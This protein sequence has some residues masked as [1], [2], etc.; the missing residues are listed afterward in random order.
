MKSYVA[1]VGRPNVGKST[2]FN[3]IT[4]SRKAIVDDYPGVTRDRIYGD[5][6]WD[7]RHFALIDTGGFSAYDSEPFTGIIRGQILTAIQESDVVLLLFDGREGL[8]PVDITICEHLRLAGKPVLYLVN[9][10]DDPKHESA[11]SEFYRLGIDRLYPIS[12]S[13]GL[14]IGDVMDAVTKHLSHG[15][16]PQEPGDVLRLSVLGRPNVGKSSLINRI[17]DSDRLVVSSIPGTTRDAVDTMCRVGGQSYQLIDTAG[18]RRK[19]SV[20][21]KLEKFSV[22]KA[23]KAIDRSHIVLLLIDAA[24]GIVDQDITI[25]SY[26]AKRHRGCIIVLNKWDLAP[27]ALNLI[28]NYVDMVRERIKFLSFAPVLTTSALTGKGVMKIFNIVNEVSQQYNARIPT[29]RLNTMFQEIF[30]SHEPP[31]HRGRLVRCYYAAQI[32]VRPPTFVCFVNT[33]EGI[34]VSYERYVLNRIRP[35][36][37]LTKTPVR[38]IFRKRKR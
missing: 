11:V 18:I 3:R 36:S 31:R 25:A 14:G 12:A 7:E 8:N 21:Q 4:R 29:P 23:L 26:I 34:P 17:L 1:I 5:V 13:H 22:I 6:E 10:I 33:P 35:A 30:M 24:Q 15:E 16:E 38:I 27:K 37:G 19:R 28:S 2:L 20:Y 32:A 9:K